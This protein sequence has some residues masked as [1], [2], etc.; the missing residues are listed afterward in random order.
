MLIVV[1][2]L[3]ALTLAG[4]AKAAKYKYIPRLTAPGADLMATLAIASGNEAVD[5]NRVELLE[6]GD[7]SFPAMLE[8][9]RGAQSSIHLES[10]IFRDGEI[11]R[12]FVD[13]LARR[14][15]AGV[16][17]RLL[18]DAIG[19]ASF[20]DEN[21]RTLEEA[22]ARVEFFRPI[23]FG[24]LKKI[25]L[26]THRKILVVD[27]RIA[28]T[29]GICIDDA[30][31]GNA[32]RPDRWRETQVRVEGPVVR[33]MQTAFARAWAE[34]TSEIL[35]ARSLY[36]DVPRSGTIR[37]Q[38]MDSTP[39]FDTNPARLTFLTAIA[40]ARSSIDVT[41]A[42]FVPDHDTREALVH[43]AQRGVR[44]R[45]IL[46]S[47]ITDVKAVRYAGRIYYA[48]LLEAGVEIYEYQPAQLHSK[49]LVVDQQWASVGSTNLDRRS[50][51]YNYESNLNIF[52]AGFVRLMLEM[53]ERDLAKSKRV[54]LEE[55][56]KRPF[57]EKFLERFYGIFRNHY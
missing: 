27:A 54:T 39:G 37:C 23:H 57:G 24:N 6:N 11:G 35:S 4:C 15:R 22:G 19:S 50:F 36:P 28:F 55:W 18:L 38:V 34:A 49:T 33:Q 21:V 44:I 12:Q 9:I 14:A 56:K 52:D 16:Q 51:Q 48:E 45:L 32:D 1:L 31:L 30:W 2:A 3:V 53:F 25:N 5:G 20:G 10:Y 26:R 29:G 42:Y 47:R 17:V 8:A 40:A 7:A 43:A 13:A 46:P 41:N